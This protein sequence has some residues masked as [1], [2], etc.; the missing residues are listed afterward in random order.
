MP[1]RVNAEMSKIE[2]PG[3]VTRMIGSS[4]HTR[5]RVAIGL[6]EGACVCWPASGEMARFAVDMAEPR[7]GLTANGLFIAASRQRLSAYRVDGSDISLVASADLQHQHAR[8]IVPA[9]PEESVAIVFAVGLV[10]VMRC[11]NG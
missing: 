2:L 10:Q 8:A 1:Q 9:P 5:P 4:P 3:R 7:L 6:E 11:V